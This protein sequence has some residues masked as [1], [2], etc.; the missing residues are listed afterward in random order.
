MDWLTNNFIANMIGPD[1]LLF[2]ACVIAITLG[3][4][5]WRVDWQDPTAGQTPPRLPTDPDPYEVAYLRGGENEVTR[6]AVFGLIQRGY[7]E[8]GAETRQRGQSRGVQ[9]VTQASCPPEL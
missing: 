9:R 1:F 2:Y 4:C 3:I 5:R 8:I 6:L 7:L